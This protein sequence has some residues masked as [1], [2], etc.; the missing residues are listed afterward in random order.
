M[1]SGERFVQVEVHHVHAEI[2]RTDFADK[3]IH[4]GAVHVEQAAFGVEDIGDLVD[5]LL[6]D[7]EG[8]RIREHQRGDVFVHL[9]FERGDV[10]HAA[11]FDFRFST[12]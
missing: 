11:G 6:E 12:S 9:R 4:V 2:S 10:D 1:R 7:A 3:G 5:L 8:V